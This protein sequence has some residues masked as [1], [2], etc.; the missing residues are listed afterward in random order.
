MSSKKPYNIKFEEKQNFFGMGKAK[1]WVLLSNPF[2]PTLIRNKLI[3]DLA[4]NLSFVFSPKS[5][6]MDVWLNDIFMGNY[7]I[8]E[9]IE[10]QGSRI[11]YDIDKGDFLFELIR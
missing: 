3:Y 8:S 10:F 7:Q 2:D 9:K 6:F 11:P 1:K 5:Y 4:S